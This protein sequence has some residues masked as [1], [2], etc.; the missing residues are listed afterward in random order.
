MSKFSFIFLV[1]LALTMF[2]LKAQESLTFSKV[3]KA[4]S[5]DKTSLF[6]IINDWFASTY[7]SANDVIQMTDKDAGVLIGKGVFE[8]SF[9][10]LSYSCYDGHVKYTIK[11]YVKDKRFKVILTNFI[12]SVNVGHGHSCNL[13]L[14]TMDEL[15][16]TSGMSK[17]YHNRVWRDIK[18]KAQIYSNKI[19]K[20]LENKVNESKTNLIDDN[21]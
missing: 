15:Y 18:I 1:L 16:A 8:Y 13:G 4:D 9:G 7:N 14:I 5:L 21:W 17:K 20:S 2:H 19:F 12:H 10:K 6:V 11:V 3:I